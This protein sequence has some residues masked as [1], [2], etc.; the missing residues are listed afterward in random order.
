[1]MRLLAFAAAVLPG[2]ASAEDDGVTSANVDQMPAASPNATVRRL[3]G[4][5]GDFGKFIGLDNAWA[6][7]AIKQLGDY[8]ESHERNV[9]KNSGLKLDRGPNAPW[10][11]GGLM[12][13]IPFR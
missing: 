8:S 4:K 9:G 1:M 3:L 7:N 13:P 5:T 10:S 12:Y 11:Q 6:Y 2:V